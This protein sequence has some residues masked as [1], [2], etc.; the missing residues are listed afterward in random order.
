[1][2]GE[3]EELCLLSV[4]YLEGSQFYWV[5]IRCQLDCV[6][7]IAGVVMEAR[8]SKDTRSGNAVFMST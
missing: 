3:K 2:V 7:T 6:P 1:M 4:E 8:E 5:L